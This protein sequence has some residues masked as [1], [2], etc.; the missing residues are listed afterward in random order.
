MFKILRLITIIKTKL[1]AKLVGIDNFGNLYF[2][3]NTQKTSVGKKKRFC[4]YNGTSES[5]RVPA[6][7]HSWL[8]YS[9]DDIALIKFLPKYPWQ[10]EHTINMTGT[11]FATI[12]QNPT[13]QQH[14]SSWKPFAATKPELQAH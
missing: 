9:H 4:I 11:N 13:K 2:E 8:H 14:Y 6:V 12:P 7:F 10:K 1:F 3:H 5:S